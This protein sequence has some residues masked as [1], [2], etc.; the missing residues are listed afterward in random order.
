M[1]TSNKKLYD[2]SI[3]ETWSITLSDETLVEVKEGLKEERVAFEDR[4]EFI[5][6]A[7]DIRMNESSL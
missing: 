6:K 7:I 3:F 1:L 4:L 2:E 5:K